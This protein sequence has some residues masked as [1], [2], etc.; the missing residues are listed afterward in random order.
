MRIILT[1][2]A[3]LAAALGTCYAGEIEDQASSFA[4]IYAS[5][6]LKHLTN[7]DELRVNLKSIKKLPPEKAALFLAGRSGDAWPVPNKHGL[8]VLAILTE[9]NMCFVYARRADT[10]IAE[11]LF[12]RMLAKAPP[13]LT[14]KLA[15]EE[16]RQTDANGPIH[17]ISYV[18]STPNAPK[19]M[20]FTLTTA[21]SKLAQLQAMASAAIISE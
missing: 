21:S 16:R 1:A 20:M 8:F 2:V 19:K 10:E 3:I 7:L 6:C 5:T 12:M 9:T 15:K 11:D 17:T 18:W 4:K 14:S 13:P